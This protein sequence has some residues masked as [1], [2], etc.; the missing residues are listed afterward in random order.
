[1]ATFK[2]LGIGETFVFADPVGASIGT[3]WVK[4]SPRKYRGVLGYDPTHQ[5]SVGTLSVKVVSMT[6]VEFEN[7]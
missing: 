1:M 6:K 3:L 7:R 4:E 5:H 2:D